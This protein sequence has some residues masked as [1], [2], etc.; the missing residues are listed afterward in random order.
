MEIPIPTR[1]LLDTNVVNFTLDWGEAIFDGGEIPNK[2]SERGVR[3]ILA[4]Q[5]IFAAGQRA[6]WQLAISPKTHEEIMRTSN[7]AKRARLKGWFNEV[8]LY[9]RE[10]F[11]E[12]GLND[13]DMASLV[14]RL[15]SSQ[16]L[17]VF[18]DTPDREL[19]A[20]AIAYKC[21]TFCT[22][23]Y[24]SILRHREKVNL[25]LLPRFITPTEWWEELR[26]YA[27]LWI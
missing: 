27:A 24:R 1:I 13:A 14:V 10:F 21:D 9:W 25:A 22:R 4:L 11:D 2:L 5:G 19:I 6:G 3:D 12:E 18:P 7:T 15:S 8:W 26:P 17:T 16:C 20:Y 23:D